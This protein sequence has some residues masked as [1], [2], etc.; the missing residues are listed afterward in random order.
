MT[1]YRVLIP[2]R[3]WTNPEPLWPVSAWMSE[4][5][6]HQFVREWRETM[7]ETPMRVVPGVAPITFA[8]VGRGGVS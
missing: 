2:G 8:Y 4:R 7:P 1:A 6:A 5:D 3:T